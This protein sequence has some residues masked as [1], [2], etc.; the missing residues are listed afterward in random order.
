[1]E[2]ENRIKSIYDYILSVQKSTGDFRKWTS[3]V[4]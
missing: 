4:I 1:M 3:K 2:G